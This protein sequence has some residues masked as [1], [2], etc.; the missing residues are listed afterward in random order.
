MNLKYVTA[1]AA[2]AVATL[3]LSA[4]VNAQNAEGVAAIVNDKVIS[5]FDVRQ[6]ANMLL[7]FAN[8]QP[9]PELLEACDRQAGG[10]VAFAG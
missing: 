8:L 2:I 10:A 7:M 4:P 5:T 9:T 6:R 3:G 1:A